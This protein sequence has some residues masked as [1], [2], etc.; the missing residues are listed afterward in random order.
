MLAELAVANAAFSV[1][2]TAISNTGDLAKVAHKIAEY[3]GAKSSIE[4]AARN[5]KAKG[6]QGSDI[7]SFMALEDIRN[8]EL[9][10][11][12]HMIWAGRAGLWDD[13]VKFQAEA[14]MAK[15][16]EEADAKIAANE[17]IERFMWGAVAITLIGGCAVLI[18]FVL[19]L[20]AL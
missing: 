17:M 8:H 12:E 19:F 20:K 15:K 16:K 13:W 4:A 6:K 11:K 10:L 2:K 14:R 18:Y 7:E 5:D 3:S 1:I 9:E